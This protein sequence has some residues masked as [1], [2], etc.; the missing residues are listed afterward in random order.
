MS[1]IVEEL[2]EIP[3]FAAL[4]KSR[5]NCPA[6][7]E[8]GQTFEIGVGERLVREGDEGAF[9]VVLEGDLQVLKKSADDSEILLATHTRGSFFGELPLLL[10]VGFFAS[11]KAVSPTRVW[12]LEESAFWEM[13]STCPDVTRQIMQTMATR[14]RNLEAISQTNQRL[15]SLGTMAAG[16]THE[17]NNPASGALHATRDLKEIAAQLPAKTCAM[18]SLALEKP[19]YEFLAEQT[20]A[21]L[22][23][24]GSGAKLSPLDRSDAEAQIE[25]WLFE[26]GVDDETL[27]PVL[28]GAR[29]GIET[30]ETIENEVQTPHLAAVLGWMCGVL[31]LEEAANS[32]EESARRIAEIVSRVKNYSHLDESPLG[33]FDVRDGLHSTLKMLAHKLRPM[34]VQTDFRAEIP[35][36]WGHEAEMNQVWTNLLDNAADAAGETDAPQISV[37][38]RCDGEKIAVQIENNGQPIAP[39]HRKRLFEP[40]FTTKGVG[41]GTGLGLATSYR[42]V[43]GRHGGDIVVQSDENATR[44]TV[45][46][47]VRAANEGDFQKD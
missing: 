16:L 28:T 46:L 20:R 42:I 41:K 40:F 32:V 26:R 31:S 22:P 27:A 6:F 34:E 3:L 29:V 35:K 15:V 47:P 5:N 30:L 19:T 21:L 11:G 7:I 23:E 9:F 10:G 12:K 8:R 13:L 33:E 17:L 45:L 43:H 18:H 25:D 36:I 2:R 37:S 24:A 39:E 1:Q 4:L 14:V 38:V 44:F